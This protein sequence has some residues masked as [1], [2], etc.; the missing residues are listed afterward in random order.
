M[1]KN[2][3]HSNDIFA[4]YHW[5]TRKGGA[6]HV[7]VAPWWG[8]RAAWGKEIWAM[9]KET[10][11]LVTFDEGFA[12]DWKKVNALSLL[13]S[14]QRFFVSA[15]CDEMLARAS[16]QRLNNLTALNSTKYTGRRDALRGSC[17]SNEERGELL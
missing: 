17:A 16:K 14:P 1:A 10:A 9:A 4:K 7:F 15:H 2:M 6:D 3:Q 11:V 12:H 13:S 8:A 5:W